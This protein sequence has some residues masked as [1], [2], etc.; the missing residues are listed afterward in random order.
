MTDEEKPYVFGAFGQP[1][2]RPGWKPGNEGKTYR[3]SLLT[4]EEVEGLLRACGAS[5]SGL[6]GRAAIGLLY[7]TGIE[8]AEAVALK[9][10]DLD[11]APSDERV[12]VSGSRL[13]HRWLALDAP[14]LALLAPWLEV[15]RKW[16]GERLLCITDGPGRG[17]RPWHEKG[18]RDFLSGA[19]LRAGIDVPGT[20]EKKVKPSA[21]RFS[22]AAELMVEQWPIP[23]IQAV[24]GTQ[25]FESF[26]TIME[27]LELR[28]PEAVEVVPLIR[29]HRPRWETPPV[30]S[31]PRPRASG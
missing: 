27:H 8:P 26:A 9:L 16:G 19:S 28:Q 21:F 20:E 7:R 23:Y 24:L 12:W 31:L 18:L 10:S 5:A 29:H 14:A 2:A 15:R 25:K 17:V 6:R 3:P 13:T 11:L 1:G 30:V 4:P 22:L